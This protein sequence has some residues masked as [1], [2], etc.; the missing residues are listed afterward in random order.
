MSSACRISFS[1]ALATAWAIASAL[2]STREGAFSAT[3]GS[4]APGSQALAARP[5]HLRWRATD[6]ESD[7]PLPGDNLIANADLPATRAIT[8]RAL[9]R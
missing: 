4:R 5:R 9:W 8:I 2:G 1:S 3:P 7:E 6:Q